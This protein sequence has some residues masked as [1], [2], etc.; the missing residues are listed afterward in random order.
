MSAPHPTI[1]GLPP[2]IQQAVVDRIRRGVPA[3]QAIYAYGSRFAGMVHAESDL[4]LALLLAPT[5]QI[6]AF[7]L[8]QLSGDL[9]AIA[10]CPVDVTILDY[11]K[12]VVLCKEVVATGQPIFIADA[13]TV[14]HFEMMTLSLYAQLS[15][16]RKPVIEAYTLEPAHG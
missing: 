11:N 12:S 9:E 16:E 2:H 5:T 10:G 6:S 8:F 13:T 7:D 3:V 15:E 1:I 4:D 14:A